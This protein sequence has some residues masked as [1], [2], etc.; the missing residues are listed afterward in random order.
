VKEARLLCGVLLIASATA[1]GSS[2]SATK[3]DN[4][5]AIVGGKVYFVGTPKCLREL[6]LRRM[7]GIWV[8]GMEHSVFYEGL[9]RPPP[10]SSADNAK[11][12]GN[13][14]WLEQDP[15]DLLERHGYRFDGTTHAYRVEF[16][17]T[18]SNALGVYGHG[19]MF[20]RGALMIR[21]LGIEEIRGH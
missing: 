16:I 3:N 8:L 19:G 11:T 12:L 17:G 21:L 18:R 14:V 5:H 6:P 7:S 9:R 1:C 4:C 2:V 20:G 13:E 15:P 10:E